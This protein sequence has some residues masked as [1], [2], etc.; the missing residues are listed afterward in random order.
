MS[1][2]VTVEYVS[3]DYVSSSLVTVGVNI[4][5]SNG[6]SYT[7]RIPTDAILAIAT[8]QA[9]ETLNLKN[10]NAEVTTLAIEA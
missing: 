5:A 7:V 4:T 10:A 3:V 2:I 1:N 8:A 9:L 6:V